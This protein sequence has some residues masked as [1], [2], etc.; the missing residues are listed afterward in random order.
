MLQSNCAPDE[1]CQNP[2]QTEQ[3]HDSTISDAVCG[4]VAAKWQVIKPGGMKLQNYQTVPDY[5]LLRRSLRTEQHKLGKVL[6][7][8]LLTV[9]L[10]EVTKLK[11][12]LLIRRASAF[13][14][15]VGHSAHCPSVE[16]RHAH[17]LWR[18]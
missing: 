17:G 1:E 16:A 5:A 10:T 2:K 3:T 15:Q 6:M 14:S 8:M 7:A 4:S 13:R 18:Q 11:S 9:A 12:K